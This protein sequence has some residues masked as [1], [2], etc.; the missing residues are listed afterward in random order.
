[1]HEHKDCEHELV[2]CP[3]CDVVYCKKCKKEWGKVVTVTVPVV[4]P[5]P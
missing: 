5:W 3:H 4:T 2:Y 1:V